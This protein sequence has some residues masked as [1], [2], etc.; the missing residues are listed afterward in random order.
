MI[1]E[2][3]YTKQLDPEIKARA[4]AL[5]LSDKDMLAK[6]VHTSFLAGM[7]MAMRICRNRAK[8]ARELSMTTT[9]VEM[10]AETCAGLIRICQVE[11]GSGR[12][13]RPKFT[14]EELDEMDRIS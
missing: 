3:E 14:K 5:M 12:M 10:E 11:I 4:D 6:I 7:Q 2:D 8:D 1:D 9:N 13:A